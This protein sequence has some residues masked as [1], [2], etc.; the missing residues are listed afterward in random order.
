MKNIIY[1]LI[2][3]CLISI[4]L[5][6]AQNPDIISGQYIVVLKESVAK[7]TPNSS[8]VRDEGQVAG[9]NNIRLQNL[10]KVKSVYDKSGVTKA[11]IIAEFSDAAVGFSAK[12]STDEVEKIKRDP[13]VAGVYP[14]YK[15]SL[16]ETS[17][18]SSAGIASG[19]TIPCAVSKTGGSQDGSTKNTWIWVVGTGIDL[20]HPDLNVQ[21]NA[22]Y[23]KSF[24]TGQSIDDGN[25]HG[26]FMA[27]LAAAKNN[28][29]GIV[30]V[31]AGAKVV[32]IKVLNNAGS[33][34]FASIIAG[35]NH[36]AARSISGDVVILTFAISPIANCEHHNPILH[37]A[38]KNLA[39][40]G[41]WVIMGAGATAGN[42]NAVF[43]ACI[44][45]TRILTIGC[46]SCTNICCGFGAWG[47]PPVD[48]VAVGSSVYSTYKGGGYIT[49]S[50]SVA[51]AALVAGICHQRPSTGPAS[52]S[53]V[54]CNGVSYPI[55]RL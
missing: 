21:T 44:N 50:S 41:V 18:E 4:S 53:N 55:A 8:N 45:G 13:N 26:T 33:G 31:S 32:P 17:T 37:D 3:L 48:F 46:I 19:Q 34:S 27:G 25:G 36:I 22:L 39:S 28:N 30:G 7:P 47:K 24:I 20:N 1:F 11:K 54:T 2:A 35:L 29:I 15:V 14:D 42:A 6:N 10:S 43:P 9:I 52:A 49:W 40:K 23:A 38:I 16:S 51:P 12:L 5:L